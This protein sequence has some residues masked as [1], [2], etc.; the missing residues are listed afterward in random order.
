MALSPKALSILDQLTKSSRPICLDSGK[1]TFSA[2]LEAGVRRC[3]SPVGRQMCLFGPGVVPASP[4]V[5]PEGSKAK[6]TSAT[7]G[8]NSSASFG[9]DALNTCLVS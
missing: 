1:R 7:S 9:S 5:V 2:G 6:E 3:A 4:S 8:R